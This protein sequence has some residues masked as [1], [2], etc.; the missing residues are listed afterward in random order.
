MG[1]PDPQ[2]SSLE[3]FFF[4]LWHGEAV[5]SSGHCQCPFSLL[6]ARSWFSLLAL[7]L[8]VLTPPGS[9]F[10]LNLAAAPWLISTC[11]PPVPMMKPKFPPAA[12]ACQHPC[13]SFR[14]QLTL[15][16]STLFSRPLPTCV[17]PH[18]PV[19]VYA[20]PSVCFS[21]FTLSLF[22]GKA[23]LPFSHP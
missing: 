21:L 23:D 16:P 15:S 9:S 12:P 14:P 2:I 5:L 4:F 22:A 17:C 7:S 10:A 6:L 3:S 20:V 13:S 8:L 19:F 11:G 18:L 1:M